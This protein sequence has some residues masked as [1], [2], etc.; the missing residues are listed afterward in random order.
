MYLLPSFIF[1]IVIASLAL[2]TLSIATASEKRVQD[3]IKGPLSV[4]VLGSGAPV[5]TAGRAS[6]SFLIFVE[7]KP[8]ILMDM[9]GGSF[10]SLAQS[11][12]N[13]ADVEHFL[14]THLHQDHTGDMSIMVKTVFF[15]NL[16]KKTQRTAAFNFYG[17]KANGISF[18]KPIN[19]DSS[20]AQYP[21]TAEYVTAHYDVS[22]GMERYLNVFAPA[23]K[24]GKFKYQANDINSTFSSDEITTV[25]K[26][27]DGLT[28][29]SIA[30]KHG[31][32]PAVAYRIEYQGYSIVW[33]GDTSSTT[34]NMIKLASGADILIYDTA[35]LDNAPP[36]D[37][38]IHQLHTTPTRMAEV[39]IA[40]NPRR[41]VLAHITPTTEDRLDEVKEIV[42]KAGFHGKVKFAKD[43]KVYNAAKR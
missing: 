3:K 35:I 27:D 20:V 39:V 15:H 19:S 24:A 8:R 5:A 37:S 2:T 28:V 32:V 40:A 1:R 4:V 21:G 13:I 25:F 42:K 41:L 7:G 22:T 11:G 43:L 12:V 6:S 14:L 9:G 10:K 38:V 34:D 33:S 17:P 23:I 30:V 29:K 16:G 18:P 26:D 31:P 36:V